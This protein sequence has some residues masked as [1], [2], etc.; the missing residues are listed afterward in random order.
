MPEELREELRRGFGIIISGNHREVISRVMSII[1]NACNKLWAVGDV[2]CSTA[3]DVGCIPKAC[4]IDGRTLRTLRTGLPEGLA[5][6]LFNNVIKIRNPAGT[7]SEEAIYAVKYC[8]GR[9]RVLVLVDGEEDLIG[10]AVLLYANLGE[11]LVYG[12]PNVGVDLIKVDEAVRS[13]AHDMIS[14]FIPDVVDYF[15]TK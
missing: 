4:F 1:G 5:K 2:V 6:G 13:K 11:Y 3:L 8:V 15:N 12:L 9:D 7:L 14:K 10:L